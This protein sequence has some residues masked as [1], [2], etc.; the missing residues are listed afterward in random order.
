MDPVQKP[1]MFPRN[2]LTRRLN[3]RLAQ[4]IRIP[5]PTTIRPPTPIRPTFQQIFDNTTRATPS[6]TASGRLQK[7]CLIVCFDKY[8]GFAKNNAIPWSIREDF[9]MLMDVTKRS[10]NGKKNVIVMGKNTWYALP[11][12]SR[13]LPDRINKVVSSSMTYDDL[14][15]TNCTKTETYLW[16]HF[17]EAMNAT[18]KMDI[19]KVFIGGGHEIYKEAL[20]KNF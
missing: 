5:H 4:P 11:D 14:L 13:G 10:V 1:L 18:K 16:P 3:M 20:K 9:L 7:H 12:K 19:N 17:F 2:I 8:F 6:L 15:K